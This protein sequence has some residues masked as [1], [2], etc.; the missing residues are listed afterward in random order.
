MLRMHIINYTIMPANEGYWL[1]LSQFEL[2]L[3]KHKFLHKHQK[4][5]YYQSYNQDTKGGH[6][7][8]QL[9]LTLSREGYSIT[10]IGRFFWKA[11][12]LYQFFH[13][14]NHTFSFLQLAMYFLINNKSICNSIC[15]PQ[16]KSFSS[17]NFDILQN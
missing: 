2:S 3:N 14:V 15:L 17:H 11:F 12:Y 13:C 7:H 10:I 4:W 5:G 16:I 8:P 6:P 9:K 1:C